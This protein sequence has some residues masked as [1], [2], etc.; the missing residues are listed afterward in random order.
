MNRDI[1]PIRAMLSRVKSVDRP[2]SADA[3]VIDGVSVEAV[4][5]H[6][7]IA[8]ETG[9]IVTDSG[10]SA[11]RASPNNGIVFRLSWAG[12]DFGDAAR[13]ERGWRK[14][15]ATIREREFRRSVGTCYSIC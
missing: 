2:T 10:R 9:L 4:T 11:T 6:A 15:P 13:S 14:V 1:A 7:A 12:H 8:D 5:Y 3:I